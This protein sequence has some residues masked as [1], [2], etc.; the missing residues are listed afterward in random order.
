MHFAAILMSHEKPVSAPLVLVPL[1]MA[2]LP[3]TADWL[4]LL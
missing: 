2:Q 4:G 1:L 3:A